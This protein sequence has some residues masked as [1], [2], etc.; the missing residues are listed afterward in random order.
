[1]NGL[2]HEC[3]RSEGCECDTLSNNQSAQLTCGNSLNKTRPPKQ[4]LKLDKFDGSTSLEVH[5]AKF[6]AC[7]RY[8]GWDEQDKF[9]HL[10]ASLVQGAA[11][12]LWDVDSSSNQSLDQLISLLKSRFGSEDQAE[13][14]RMEIKLRRRRAGES[15]QALYQEIKRLIALA[16]PGPSNPTTDIVSRDA[17]LDALDDQAMALRVR[18]RE[19]A[20]LEQALKIAVRFEAYR[21]AD[22]NH[23]Y[24]SSEAAQRKAR[25]VGHAAVNRQSDHS[26]NQMQKIC[27]QL[28]RLNQNFHMWQTQAGPKAPPSMAMPVNSGGNTPM[29]LSV[30]PLTS[31]LCPTA[32]SFIPGN[33]SSYQMSAPHTDQHVNSGLAVRSQQKTS[34]RTIKSKRCFNCKSEG[35]LKAQC[36]FIQTN[37]SRRLEIAPDQPDKLARGLK[38]ERSASAVYL[39]LSIGSTNEL[40]LVDTGCEASILPAHLAPDKAWQIGPSK[41]EAANDTPISILGTLNTD[42]YLN[43]FHTNANF[44]ISKDVD[45]P[46]LGMDFI[47]SHECQ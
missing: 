43:G 7:A 13:K 3:H 34:K 20:N 47:E 28:E 4:W 9:A 46:M 8:N 2:N 30:Q 27:D 25:S 32:A 22:D 39:T 11:Q 12:C 18:E 6:C 5:L 42:I 33:T 16:Y 26:D 44:L 1:L 24:L 23:G 38:S 31:N 14:F 10:Q 29:T 35:H 21:K 15:L 36:P 37:Q 17:F 40:C 19:P 45:E 41:L